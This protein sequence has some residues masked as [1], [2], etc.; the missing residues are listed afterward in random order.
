MAETARECSEFSRSTDP[1][2]RTAWAQKDRE[3]HS[4]IIDLAGN[5]WLSEF[6]DRLNIQAQH[7]RVGPMPL[8]SEALSVV[9][10][11]EHMEIVE[12]LRLHDLPRAQAAVRT[13]VHNAVGRAMAWL[14]G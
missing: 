8:G 9:H 2:D 3:F 12:S 5:P 10:L 4:L 7:L 6:F 13:H 11:A 14:E 1:A